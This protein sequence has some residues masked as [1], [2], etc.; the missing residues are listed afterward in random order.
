MV[1]KEM[2]EYGE[3]FLSEKEIPWKWEGDM[4][5]SRKLFMVSSMDSRPSALVHGSTFEIDL[6]LCLLY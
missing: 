5:K 6:Q 3:L 4:G 1:C 2:D